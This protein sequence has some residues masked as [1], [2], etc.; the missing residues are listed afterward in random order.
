MRKSGHAKDDEKIDL[1][2]LSGPALDKALGY[3]A[4]QKR[5]LEKA[6][7]EFQREAMRRQRAEDCQFQIGIYELAC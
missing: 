1:K 2:A 5:A 7:E 3:L 6:E 4:A